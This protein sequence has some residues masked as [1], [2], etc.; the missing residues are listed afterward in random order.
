MIHNL[1]EMGGLAKG[2]L[3]ELD[4]RASFAG[5]RV[6]ALY[7][8]LGA[9]KTAFAKELAKELGIEKHI[10][11]PTFVILKKYHVKKSEIRNP[12]SETNSNVQNL[13][14]ETLIHID[15]YRLGS[16][17]DLK[18][19]G[20]DELVKDPKNLILIEWPEKIAEVLPNNIIKLKFQYIDEN[21]RKVVF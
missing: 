21:T 1:D 5:A 12:K 15:A 18:T 11:S 14:F 17:E 7:G 13:K 9:G 3:L 19:L 10:T 4:K 20:W 6:V 2:F 16:G 8:D